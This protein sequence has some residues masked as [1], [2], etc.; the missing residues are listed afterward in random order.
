MVGE[1]LQG[2][3]LI[4]TRIQDMKLGRGG[5]LGGGSGRS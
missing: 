4:A 3:T 1:R 5:E 2:N